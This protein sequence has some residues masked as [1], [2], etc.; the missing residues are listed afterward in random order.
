MA[1][2]QTLSNSFHE[3]WMKFSAVEKLLF[4]EENPIAKIV[5]LSNE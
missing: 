3:K 5:Q 1:A 4:I 2:A